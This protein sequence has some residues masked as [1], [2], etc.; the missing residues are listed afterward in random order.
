LSTAII[1]RSLLAAIVLV[2]F[3]GYQGEGPVFAEQIKLWKLEVVDQ[4][5]VTGLS[6]SVAL[7]SNSRPYI[8]Y[9]DIT[10]GYVQ[11]ASRT[12]GGWLIEPL[13]FSDG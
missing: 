10:S 3:S 7:D 4:D 8:S 1:V 12:S 13:G 2:V 9:F 6:T 11:V 5:G